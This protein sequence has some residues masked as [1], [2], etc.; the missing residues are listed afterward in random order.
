M[1][2][3]EIKYPTINLFERFPHQEIDT[4]VL[5]TDCELYR[6]HNANYGWLFYDESDGGRFNGHVPNSLPNE[7]KDFNF[8][9]FGGCYIASTPQGAISESIFRNAHMN[10]NMFIERSLLESRRMTEIVIPEG[11]EI[12]LVDLTS[13]KT[14]IQLGLDTQIFSTPNY[15]VCFGWS[16]LIFAKGYDGIKYRGRN[17][18]DDCYVIFPSD[19]LDVDF[20]DSVGLLSSERF[21]PEIKAFAQQLG[22]VV[23]EA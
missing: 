21:L 22:M 18:E 7:L 17:F 8:S 2:D 1:Q 12:K 20:G 3:F 5:P 9:T 19:K 13:H 10:K 11:V 14:R 6:S 16:Q 15:D 4:F 23:E